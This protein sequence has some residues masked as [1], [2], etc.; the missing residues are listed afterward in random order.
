MHKA[1]DRH[2]VKRV[3]RGELKAGQEQLNTIYDKYTKKY[4]YITSQG[5]SRAFRDDEDY[6]LL[7]SL[8]VVDGERGIVTKAD[9]FTKQT[10][11]AR[12]TAERVETAVEALNLS[13]CEHNGVNIPYMLEVYEPDISGK[14]EEFRRGQEES[15]Q[16]G[17]IGG[18]GEPVQT[19]SEETVTGLKRERLIEELQGVIFLNPQKCLPHDEDRGWET[20]DEYLSG[21]VRDKLRAAKAAA[22]ERPELFAGNVAALEQV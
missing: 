21:N 10:I 13:I 5:N 1:P 20:A 11:R 2:P 4:G 9:M 3:Q 22:G 8:E 14:L 6:P 19:L 16:G 7:C 15:R 18:Q 17:D 12:E